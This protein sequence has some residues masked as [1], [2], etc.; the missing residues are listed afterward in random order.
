MELLI[1]QEQTSQTAEDINDDA[2]N[3]TTIVEWLHHHYRYLT[4]DN[5]ADVLI[6]DQLPMSNIGKVLRR[7]LTDKFSAGKNS[8]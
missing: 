4:H 1:P 7:N 3:K 5:V 6:V 8:H 2:I